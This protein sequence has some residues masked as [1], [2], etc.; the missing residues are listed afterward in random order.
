MTNWTVLNN[1]IRQVI[2]SN[3][4]R[5]ITGQILQTALLNIVNN[6]GSLPAFGGTAT[7]STN[8]GVHDG[9]VCYIATAEGTYSNFNNIAI[10]KSEVPSVLVCIDGTWTKQVIG[11]ILAADVEALESSLASEIGR[12]QANEAELQGKVGDLEGEIGRRAEFS[13]TSNSRFPFDFVI[14][15]TYRFTN[16]SS[17][18]F[19]TVYTATQA[20]G[21]TTTSIGSIADGESKEF[22]INE[23]ATFVGITV[24]N[25]AIDNILSVEELDGI[26]YDLDILKTKTEGVEQ[27]AA[28]LDINM[29]TLDVSVFGSMKSVETKNGY[30]NGSTKQIVINTYETEVYDVSLLREREIAIENDLA[31]SN[32]RVF[33]FLKTLDNWGSGNTPDYCDG[34]TAT[35]FYSNPQKVVV[36][37]DARYL[38]VTSKTS[39]SANNKLT[40]LG[41]LNDSLQDVDARVN[42]ILT[43]VNKEDYWE[44]GAIA[45]ANGWAQ[46]STARIRTKH[47]LGKSISS[48]KAING[49]GFYIYAYATKDMKGYVG[50]WTGN[51]FEIAQPTRLTEADILGI[52]NDNDYYFAITVISP[53]AGNIGV[54]EYSNIIIS[55]LYT[56]EDTEEMSRLL[57]DMAIFDQ[58]YLPEYIFGLSDTTLARPVTLCR[59]SVQANESGIGINGKS[60]VSFIHKTS[61]QKSVVTE[62]FKLTNKDKE[63][64]IEIDNIIL[65]PSLINGTARVLTIGDSM[66]EGGAVNPLTGQAEKYVNWASYIHYASMVNH[67]QNGNDEFLSIGAQVRHEAPFILGNDEYVNE[68]YT[69]GHSGWSTCDHLFHPMWFCVHSKTN[70]I[71]FD[72]EDAFYLLG[73]STKT[74]FDAEGYNTTKVDFN[75]SQEQR[76]EILQT[77]FGRY[78]I[79]HTQRIWDKI[80][81]QDPSFSSDAYTGTA[82]QKAMI[83]GWFD[84]VISTQIINQSRATQ[85]ANA[86]N[87][88]FDI[89]KARAYTG[90][91]N[92]TYRSAFSLQKYLDQYRNLDDEGNVLSGADGANVIGLDGK[93]YRKGTHVSKCET[94]HVAEPTHVIVALGAN[95]IL[96]EQTEQANVKL[97]LEEIRSFNSSIEVAYLMQRF[98]AGV[99]DNTEWPNVYAQNRSKAIRQ[100]YP[101]MNQEMLD[102]YADNLGVSHEIQYI[103]AYFVQAPW[104][105]A[106]DTFAYDELGRKTVLQDI[107][108]DHI[109]WFA[110]NDVGQQAYAWIL[111]TLQTDS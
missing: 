29:N 42:S 95:D 81:V 15:K 80:K 77:V 74:Y 19:F 1:A 30:I 32:G 68:A 27:K 8:P 44:Q 75:D 67:I 64:P 37:N 106:P 24:V 46:T 22:V 89:A 20:T 56:Y 3:G 14:G 85:Q 91:H 17:D 43:N 62:T 55:S 97:L 92:W 60:K 90:N 13:T 70:A 87:R 34:Y 7:P 39:A 16:K 4:T 63:K 31:I 103:P 104:N 82:E 79:D 23:Q 36:P 2:Y 61:V 21:G 109:G 76:I 105:N 100:N 18:S 108:D 51:S 40:L 12:A 110:H 47:P 86:V 65:K 94:C 45:Y 26:R 58:A 78:K 69:E 101:H 57:G 50:T 35:I 6:V 66:T 28:S 71:R 111:N 93:S 9:P 96:D 72:R 107:S 73:L 98:L 54:G 25:S 59:E 5:D 33:A 84:R 102:T 10:A 41:N 88:C 11:T 53:T 83:D 52:R 48:I 49:Y 99:F 38:V